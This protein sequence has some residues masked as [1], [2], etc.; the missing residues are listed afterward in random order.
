MTRLIYHGSGTQGIEEL[1]PQVPRDEMNKDEPCAIY[2]IA[3]KG[4]FGI[5]V[6][7][8]FPKTSSLK[9]AQ[10]DQSVQEVKKGSVVQAQNVLDFPGG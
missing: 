2:A 9:E 1:I 3:H 8:F 10:G 7:R 5:A 6:E 4:I